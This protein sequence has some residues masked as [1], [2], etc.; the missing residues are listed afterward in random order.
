MQAWRLATV[1]GSTLS[2]FYEAK[3]GIVRVE[4]RWL[5]FERVMACRMVGHDDDQHSFVVRY[6]SD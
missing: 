4:Y 6:G 3:Q 1:W 2:S 5:M